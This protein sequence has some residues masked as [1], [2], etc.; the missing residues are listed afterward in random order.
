MTKFYVT[1]GQFRILCYNSSSDPIIA[2]VNAIKTRG[3]KESTEI[4]S[5]FFEFTFFIVN[6]HG[7]SDSNTSS[8][9]DLGEVLDMLDEI[10]LSGEYKSKL[11]PDNVDNYFNGEFPETGIE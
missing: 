9:I 7:F 6:E 1:N 10:T 5:D 3:F 8:Y 11:S 4:P 2:C